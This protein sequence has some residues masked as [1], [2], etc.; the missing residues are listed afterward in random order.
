MSCGMGSLETT[1]EQYMSS[2]VGV[3]GCCAET[4]AAKKT[5]TIPKL[6]HRCN[7]RRF[8]SAL[9]QT[10]GAC[11]TRGEALVRQTTLARGLPVGQEWTLARFTLL[12]PAWY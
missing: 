6:R 1:L 2:S 3:V 7:M 5:A 9:L 8:I 4:T 11:H 10:P 12:I